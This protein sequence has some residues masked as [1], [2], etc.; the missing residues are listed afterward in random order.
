MSEDTKQDLPGSQID[1]SKLPEDQQKALAEAAAENASTEAAE[2]SGNANPDSPTVESPAAKEKAKPENENEEAQTNA[3]T[4]PKTK[5]RMEVFDE[6]DKQNFAQEEEDGDTDSD[7]EA[8]DGEGKQPKKAYEIRQNDQG[9]D[10]LVLKVNGQEVLRPVESVV[11]ETQKEISGDQKLERVNDMTK[12]LAE[13]DKDLQ[14]RE[15]RLSGELKKLSEQVK[16]SSESLSEQDVAEQ[17]ELLEKFAE[18]LLEDDTAGAAKYLKEALGRGTATPPSDQEI[19][20]QVSQMAEDRQ[21]IESKKAE[22]EQ[23]S[24]EIQQHE[25]Q[26]REQEWSDAIT[27]F[28]TEFPEI[29]KGTALWDLANTETE[30]LFRDPDHKDKPFVEVFREAGNRVRN[31]IKAATPSR[32][33]RKLTSQQHVQQRS[34]QAPAS[35]TQEQ[36][37]ETPYDAV[38]EMKRKRRPTQA[39]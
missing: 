19:E 29:K 11:R 1:V 7:E 38:M 9:E 25:N 15:L 21:E 26:R 34:T 32:A 3:S 20:A 33:E 13:W 8:G 16:Q 6:I 35:A 30:K 39:Y 17:G 22:R 37:V 2:Q 28:T 18:A 5:A 10:C 14:T 31:A 12:K 4:N 24:T 23:L 27:D 36:R